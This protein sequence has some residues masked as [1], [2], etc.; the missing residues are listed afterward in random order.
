VPVS[1]AMNGCGSARSARGFPSP[2]PAELRARARQLFVE[3]ASLGKVAAQLALKLDTVAKWSQRGSWV[4]IRRVQLRTSPVQGAVQP[5]AGVTPSTPVTLVTPPPPATS[6]RLSADSGN[7]LGTVCRGSS[8]A[9][10]QWVERASRAAEEQAQE[11]RRL[12][13]LRDQAARPCGW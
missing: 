7:R 8:R 12:R 1:L 5:V 11:V 13:E 9:L 6:Q 3:G 10:L 4:A 2:L